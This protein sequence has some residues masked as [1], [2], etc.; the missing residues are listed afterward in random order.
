[1]TFGQQVSHPA[2][3]EPINDNNNNNNNKL[4]DYVAATICPR[5]MTLTFDLEVG[6][7]VTCDLGYP[8]A[9][10]CLPRPFGFRVRADVRRLVT[11][12]FFLTYLLTYFTYATSDRRTTDADDRLMPPPSLR[13]GGIISDLWFSMRRLVE[14]GW[15]QMRSEYTASA[16]G[17]WNKI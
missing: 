10:F 3:K 11:I 4:C 14:K 13:G 1:M 5:P 12:C 17:L 8:C 9:K 7:G 16:R 2:C 15:Q 6:V